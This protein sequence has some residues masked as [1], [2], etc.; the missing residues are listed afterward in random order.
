[1][2]TREIDAGCGMSGMNRRN[3]R[4]PS[5]PALFIGWRTRSNHQ[6]FVIRHT[7]TPIKEQ[8]TCVTKMPH[9]EEADEVRESTRKATDVGHKTPFDR[10]TVP[11]FFFEDP[12]RD[13]NV[14]TQDGITQIAEHKYKAGEYTHLD[15]F[16][17][18]F[19]TYCTYNFLPMSMAPNM[20]TTLGGT[21]NLI[22]YLA[23]WYYLPSFEPK[24]GESVPPLLVAG[25]GVA[26]FLYY[27][28]DCM[29]GKQARRTGTSSPL[30]QL[31]D[32][33]ID[34]FANMALFSSA[35]TFV[36]LG[37]CRNYLYCQLLTQVTFFAAQW[38]EYYTGILPHSY[39]KYVGV[40]EVRCAFQ[41]LVQYVLVHVEDESGSCSYSY[42]IADQLR[43]GFVYFVQ[44]S[45]G[46]PGYL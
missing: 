35:Q 22:A 27:T 12:T 24:E 19:W 7:S 31:F 5:L 28:L 20:V 11:T 43:Y 4:Q 34:C 37:P 26:A 36:L 46:Q 9:S 8:P 21:A 40:T 41:L 10:T 30:G 14:L 15:N 45:T 33:G 39:G 44:Q 29:D 6:P 2:M 3:R 17:N 25:N 18:P 23:T 38:E 32:H 1:M 42:S 16:L 13:G